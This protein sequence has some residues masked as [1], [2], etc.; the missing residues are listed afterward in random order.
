M[1]STFVDHLCTP[2]SNNPEMFHDVTVAQSYGQ[3]YLQH[4]KAVYTRYNN[5]MNQPL[6]YYRVYVCAELYIILS[7]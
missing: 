1:A 5:D 7:Y 2:A 6:W 4:I 3:V